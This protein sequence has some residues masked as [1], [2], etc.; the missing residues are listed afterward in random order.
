MMKKGV[1]EVYYALSP[2]PYT[3]KEEFY[4][5]DNNRKDTCRLGR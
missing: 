4:V 3:L 2:K 1:P 5:N